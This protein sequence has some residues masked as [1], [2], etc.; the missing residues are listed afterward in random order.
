MP[1][2]WL[3]GAYRD[4]GRNAGYNSGRS[5]MRRGVQHFT[6]GSDSRN[7]GRGGFFHF[8]VHRDASRE[9][10]CTQ[11]AEADAKTWHGYKLGHYDANSEG[12]G[13]EF[14]RLVVGGINAEGLSDAQP[15]TD[16]QLD[17]GH[18]IIAFYAEWG[19][20]VQ[21]YNGPRYQYGDYEGWI[22]HQALDSDRSDGLLRF[23]WDA[24]TGGSTGGNFTVGQMEEL[25]QWEKDTRKIIL[26]VLV[27]DVNQ[28]QDRG[29]LGVWEQDTRSY[30]D[31]A[32]KASEDRII[33]AVNA[34]H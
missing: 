1:D 20:E 26:D 32:I 31:R 15:L 21:L 28:A 34:S 5:N 12:P 18:R 13:V 30:I 25:A 6:V 3:P 7:V 9:N 24:M 14:E 17:W 22:N 23:E 27:F 11:Y 10:G 19:I 2:I 29:V 4:P 16:N 8:L 33:R